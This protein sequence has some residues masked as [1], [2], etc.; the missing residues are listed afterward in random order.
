[1][2]HVLTYLYSYDD[3]RHSVPDALLFWQVPVVDDPL[4]F[5]FQ[6]TI[7]V[8]S[9]VSHWKILASNGS[10]AN[11]DRAKYVRG[12][13]ESDVLSTACGFCGFCELDSG[14][15]SFETSVGPWVPLQPRRNAPRI[16]TLHLSQEGI[17]M[18]PCEPH[19]R[20]RA[21]AVQLSL[22]ALLFH[23][24]A[25]RRLRDVLPLI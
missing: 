15:N 16:Q 4:G 2:S 6:A 23:Y 8:R 9:T 5:R 11:S 21:H 13:S 20:G 17:V 3:W 10:H 7:F 1:M 14:W 22:T 24:R 18:V 12:Y 19:I 25:R